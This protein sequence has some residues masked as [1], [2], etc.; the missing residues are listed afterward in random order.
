MSKAKKYWRSLAELEETPEFREFLHREFPVAASEFPDWGDSPTLAAID[1]RLPGAGRCFRMSLA[2]RRNHA[3]G[4][5]AGEPR[6]GGTAVLCDLG[7]TCR[8]P[9]ASAD[10]VSGRS[11]DQGRGESGTSGQSRGKQPVCT[12]ESTGAVR[13][14]SKRLAR[15]SEWK[16]SLTRG[17][18]PKSKRRCVSNSARSR[19]SKG[20]RWRC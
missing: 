11:A 2:D 3:I 15:S 5:A 20:V 17:R 8:C 16:G 19:C 12:S 9:A 4:R 1:G 6:S 13:P 18:G 10:D 14:R 7:R